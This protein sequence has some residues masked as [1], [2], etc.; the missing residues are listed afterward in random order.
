MQE[1]GTKLL[2]VKEEDSFLFH[3]LKNR[4]VESG[5]EV[6]DVSPDVESFSKYAEDAEICL[7]YLGKYAEKSDAIFR[8]LVKF[9]EKKKNAVWL[10]GTIGEVSAVKNRIEET[11]GW[12]SYKRPINL[13]ALT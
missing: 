5:Y 11:A 8:E 9:G 10:I 4:L 2:L 13:D 3:A 6:V 1:M 12:K 7:V